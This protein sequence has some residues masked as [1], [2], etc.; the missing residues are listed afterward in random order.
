ML[1]RDGVGLAVV[2]HLQAMLDLA[3]ET[4]GRAQQPS[5]VGPQQLVLDE[6]F[7]N[8]QSLRALQKRLPAGVQKLQRL[9]HE[10]DLTNPSA[11]ELDI[12][13]EFLGLNHLVLDAVFHHRDLAQNALV[14]RAWITEWLDRFDKL[15][16]QGYVTRDTPRFD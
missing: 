14:N 10:F 6:L 12:A 1:G 3:Q 15:R 7:Q 11:P 9:S 8:R 4:I 16:P 13:V 2:F 5:I